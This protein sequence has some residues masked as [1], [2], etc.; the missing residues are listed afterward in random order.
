MKICTKC[1]IEK[2]LSEFNK[3]KEN[4]IGVA[5][6]CKTCINIEQR[7]KYNNNKIERLAICPYCGQEFKLSRKDK[8]FCSKT[9]ASMKS[10]KLKC[11]EQNFKNQ[12]SSYFKEWRKNNFEQIKIRLKNKKEN[13][14]EIIAKY[15][16][17][18]STK[19]RESLRLRWKNKG[20][21]NIELLT[22]TYIKRMCVG[23]SKI[24]KQKDI[25]PEMIEL[26][27]IQIQI[28]RLI[29]QGS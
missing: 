8:I 24:L 9:C 21:F 4:K 18:Y 29:K 2:P 5:P 20:R 23:K 1:G 19:N 25:T 3:T 12:K 13:F 11:S 14:P 17:D 15:R 7:I 10:Y 27:R 26:K 28:N 6:R 16:K 22:N